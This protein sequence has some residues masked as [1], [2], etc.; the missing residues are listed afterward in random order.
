MTKP[1]K[2]P[3]LYTQIRGTDVTLM[4]EPQLCCWAERGKYI[5]QIPMSRR[6][7]HWLHQWTQKCFWE[8]VPLTSPV[9]TSSLLMWA[10][11]HFPG[12]QLLSVWAGFQLELQ[13][14]VTLITESI[15]L[16][17]QAPGLAQLQRAKA[18]CPQ[19][20]RTR[21][22]LSPLR[23]LRWGSSSPETSLSLTIDALTHCQPLLP[24]ADTKQ[25]PRVN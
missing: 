20:Q 11:Y 12:V 1:Q 22:H 23:T 10:I 8:A 15:L 18:K 25:D 3:N 21:G 7:E 9:F 19:T 14:L 16:P 13:D 24:R 6:A 17:P 5:S 2:E 4:A